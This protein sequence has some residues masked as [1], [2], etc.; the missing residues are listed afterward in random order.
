[1][2]VMVSAGNGNPVDGVQVFIDFDPAVFR[3]VK[4]RD[5]DSLTESLHSS[6]DNEFGHVGYAAGTL[7]EPIKTPFRLVSVEFE[8]A[9]PTGG[10]GSGVAFASLT[11]PRVTKTVYLGNGNT[12]SLRPPLIVVVAGGTQTEG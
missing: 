5:G 12:G 1:M 6:R 10:S 9:A 11:P 4:L 8:A 3:V 7:G 2:D